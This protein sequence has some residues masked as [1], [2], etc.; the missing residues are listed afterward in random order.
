M[1]DQAA[2]YNGSR[3][4]ASQREAADTIIREATKVG[5]NPAFMLALAVTESS[6]RPHIV[7]DD[8]KSIGLFQQTLTSAREFDLSIKEADLLDPSINARI[9]TLDMREMR[10]RYPGHT[11]GDYAESWA[12]GLTGRFIKGRRHPQKVLNLKQAVSDL[13][14]DLNVDEVWT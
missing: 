3:L 6:L 2:M 12:L 14:L 10:R 13:E 4:T 8:G 5:V 1:G 11:Y 7:G 9:S